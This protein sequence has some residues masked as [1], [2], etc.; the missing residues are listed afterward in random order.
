MSLLPDFHTRVLK[1]LGE[2]L[3]NH[4]TNMEKGGRDGHE[5]WAG[6]IAATRAAISIVNEEFKRVGGEDE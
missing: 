2:N 1:R 3:S 4:Q 6:Q 5:K